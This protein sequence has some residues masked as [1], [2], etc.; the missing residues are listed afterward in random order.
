M[1]ALKY[2]KSLMP[3]FARARDNACV[4]ASACGPQLAAGQTGYIAAEMVVMQSR[5]AAGYPI[6]LLAI[7]ALTDTRALGPHVSHVH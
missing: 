1:T 7:V 4:R 2:S 5:S 3:R 6:A